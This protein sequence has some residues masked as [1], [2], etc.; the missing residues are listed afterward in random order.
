MREMRRHMP[1]EVGND[2]CEGLGYLRRLDRKRGA[3]LARTG[4]RLHRPGGKSGI[5]GDEPVD[6]GVTTAAKLF[7][8]HALSSITARTR[9]RSP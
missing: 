7:C 8:V 1:I 4:R 9:S 3:H 2:V 6:D 5:V